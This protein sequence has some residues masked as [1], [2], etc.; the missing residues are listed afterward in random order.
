[1]KVTGSGERVRM[2]LNVAESHV[3]RQLFEELQDTLA[4][5]TADPGDPVQRR[6]YPDAYDSAEDAAAFRELTEAGLRQDRSERVDQCLAELLAAR[7]LVRTELNL[8][9]EGTQRWL[10]VLNDLR[11]TYGVRLGITEEDDNGLD[12]RDPHVGM[13]ARYLWLTAMQDMLVTA[14]MRPI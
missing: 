11:L 6:L 13:R 3:L 4:P 7:S 2:R 9:A 10:Q 12:E 14:V 8:S 1:M 5:R